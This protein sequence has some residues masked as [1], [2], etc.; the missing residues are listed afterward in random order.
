[1]DMA[2][3]R[4]YAHRTPIDPIDI[5]SCR[6]QMGLGTLLNIWGKVREAGGLPAADSGTVTKERYLSAIDIFQDLP[7]PA[8]ERLAR[9]T[10]MITRARGHTIYRAGDASET[11]FLLKKGRVQIVRETKD[12][13][14]L[15][16][17]VLGP[18]TFFGEMALVGQRFPQDSTAEAL[19]DT[20][21]CVMSRRDIEHLIL[22]YP[23]VGL[24]FLERVG[25]RLVETQAMVEEFAFKP[26]SARLAGVL[27]RLAGHDAAT[28]EITHQELADMVATYR[29][30]VTVT[31]HDFRA[32][33]LVDLGRRS[34]SI[35]NPR[36]LEAETEAAA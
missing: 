10:T 16:T 26:V 12:G 21:L 31:L 9:I 29:E 15:I 33:G 6:D 30:T 17:A 5:E 32:R 8:L 22:E 11:L 19:D 13:K 1:V 24:R 23:K 28:I 18:E 20:V 14:R 27:L 35:I 7:A 4:Y 2:P 25:A 36:G 34:I 3:W